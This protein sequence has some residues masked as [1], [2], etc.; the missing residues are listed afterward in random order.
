[1]TA[2]VSGIVLSL[3]Y[4]V[5]RRQ[6]D[7][8]RRDLLMISAHGPT[9]L[10]CG[11]VLECSLQVVI[12][13]WLLPWCTDVATVTLEIHVSSAVLAQHALAVLPSLREALSTWVTVTAFGSQAQ[14]IPH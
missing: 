4:G 14:V 8:C 7:T 3:G 9:S 1:M 6:V 10:W 2:N 13:A 12:D 11:V 5:E